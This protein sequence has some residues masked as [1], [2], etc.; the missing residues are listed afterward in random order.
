[1]QFRRLP[2]LTVFDLRS[3]VLPEKTAPDLRPTKAFTEEASDTELLGEAAAK[4]AGAATAEVATIEAIAGD[5]HAGRC[6]AERRRNGRRGS[7]WCTAAPINEGTLEIGEDREILSHKP[8][9]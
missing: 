1:M 7:G 5:A 2:L 4:A 3:L 9:G 8:G 6:P